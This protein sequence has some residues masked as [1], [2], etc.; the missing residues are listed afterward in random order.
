MIELDLT[1]INP[2]LA[3]Q[4]T[5]AFYDGDALGFVFS[6]NSSNDA[7]ALVF[8]NAKA[9]LDRR[10]YEQSLV[11]AFVGCRSNWRGWNTEIISMMF[12][13][14]DREK[15]LAAGDPLPDGESFHVYRGVAGHGRA[16]RLDGFSWTSSLEAACW[17]ALRYPHLPHPA[18][19]EAHI[20][21]REVLAFCADRNEHEFICRPTERQ[22]IKLSV[23]EMKTLS[24]SRAM[25][26]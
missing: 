18:V 13:L 5:E 17:F 19:L 26:E 11:E 12:G 25:K 4:A 1:C 15:L 24:Q 6:A 8:D 3:K 14:C 21:R 23:E 10:I 22:R 7:L 20:S 16:R 2:M 9:L